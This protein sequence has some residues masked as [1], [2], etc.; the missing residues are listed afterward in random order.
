MGETD[1][2]LI[3]PDAEERVL[4]GCG[5]AYLVAV[6]GDVDRDVVKGVDDAR[7][8]WAE[9]VGPD[10]SVEPVAHKLVAAARLAGGGH[11]A[12]VEELAEALDGDDGDLEC[13]AWRCTRS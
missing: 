11:G 9:A 12:L 1:L 8:L 10:A 7:T 5:L 13:I 2:A 4:I 3:A 6:A